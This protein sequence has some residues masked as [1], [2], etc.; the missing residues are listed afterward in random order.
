MDGNAIILNCKAYD[1][2]F[3]PKIAWS[4]RIT[5]LKITFSLVKLSDPKSLPRAINT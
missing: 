2:F 4:I 3:A 5:L 1:Y